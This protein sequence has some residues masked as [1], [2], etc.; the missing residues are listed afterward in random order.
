M[1]KKDQAQKVLNPIY[2]CYCPLGIGLM[3][4]HLHSRY[5][6]ALCVFTTLIGVYLFLY[7]VVGHHQAHTVIL[8]GE[9]LAEPSIA[10]VLK[11][12]FQGLKYFRKNG[13]N[14]R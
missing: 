4:M 8:K 7:T 1:V 3:K 12:V 13:Q 9:L 6:L 2:I 11:E 10:S 5:N 14:H